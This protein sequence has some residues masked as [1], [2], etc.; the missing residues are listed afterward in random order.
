MHSVTSNEAEKSES[1][2]AD[3]ELLALGD[4][5]IDLAGEP[6]DTA[7]QNGERSNAT[8][9]KYSLSPRVLAVS[10][11]V[12]GV[13]CLAVLAVVTAVEGKDGLSTI[14][15]ALAVLAF[16]IQI[17]VFIVQSQSTSQQM[18]RSE[19]L[20]TDTRALLVEMR[21]SARSTESMVRGQFG[22]VL[23]AFMDAVKSSDKKGGFDPDAFEQRLMRN[24]ARQQ[25]QTETTQSLPPA[26]PAQT[27][28]VRARQNDAIRRARARVAGTGGAGLRRWAIPSGGRGAGGARSSPPAVTR[29]AQAPHPLRTRQGACSGQRNVRGIPTAVGFHRR[30][31]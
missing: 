2:V 4:D 20:N 21:T 8:V 26:T 3:D 13:C 25:V 9:A 18:V 7:L 11:S 12:F 10:A 1:E 6:S 5:L 31:P 22:Q 17:M 19:Q 24:M 28:T 16:V 29:R 15:L 14:A 30:G 23:R 27:N